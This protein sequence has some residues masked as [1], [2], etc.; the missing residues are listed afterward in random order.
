MDTKEQKPSSSPPEKK[1]DGM[2]K[3]AVECGCPHGKPP[4]EAEMTKLAD[5]SQQCP[6]CGRNYK[7]A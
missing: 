3:Y 5:G 1:E 6:K 4:P 7:S 2:E